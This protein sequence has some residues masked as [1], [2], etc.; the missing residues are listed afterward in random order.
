MRGP[1]FEIG[2]HENPYMR[3]WYVIPRNRIFCIYLHNM[4]KNDDDRALHDH[5]GANVSLILRGGYKEITFQQTPISGFPLP[6]LI[7]RIRKPG[8]IVFR[9]AKTAHRLELLS[10]PSWSLFI[11][12]PK[13]RDWGFWCGPLARWVPWQQF[14]A[15][16]GGELIGRGCS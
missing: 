7:D 3:R 15:G 2:G 5:P 10:G 9:F 16:P 12:L 11:V 13:F 14:T 4:L 6:P 1:D 8:R